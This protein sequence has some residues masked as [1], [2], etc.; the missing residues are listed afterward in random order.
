MDAFER[1]DQYFFAVLSGDGDA[2]RAPSLAPIFVVTLMNLVPINRALQATPQASGVFA[3]AAKRLAGPPDRHSLFKLEA[4]AP[5]ILAASHAHI[6]PLWK[7]MHAP[8]Y[9]APA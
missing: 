5:M 7:A 2:P 9:R 8:M 3:K 6:D 4:Q 1:S